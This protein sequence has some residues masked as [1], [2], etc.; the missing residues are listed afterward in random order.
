MPLAAGSRLGSFEVL[1][2]LGAGG[3]GEVYRARDTE[4]GRDVALKILAPPFSADPD[5]LARFEREAR[6]LAA[7]NHRNIAAIHGVVR[8][9]STRALVLELVPGD[10]L[11]DRIARGPLPIDQALAIADQ[12]AEALDAAHERS[13]VHRDLKPANIKITGDG[14]VKVLDFGIAKALAADSDAST[15]ESHHTHAGVVIGTR[16]YMSPEQTRGLPVDKRTDVWAFGCVLYEML[17]GRRAFGGAT[18]TEITTAV[19]ELEPEW[20]ALPA[21]TP[22]P[23]RRLLKRTLAKDP[24]RRLRDIADA[25]IDLEEGLRQFHGERPSSPAT[26]QGFRPANTRWRVHAAWGVAVVVLLAIGFS[27]RIGPWSS[28]GV[29]EVTHLTVPLPGPFTQAWP[30]LAVS[31]DGRMIAVA[32]TAGITIRDLRSEQPR[33]LTGTGESTTP[34]FSPDGAWVGFHADGRLRKVA[35]EGGLPITIAD[36]GGSQRGF[37]WLPD[38]AIIAGHTNGPLSTIAPEGG[39]IAPLTVLDRARDETSHRWPH[40]IHGHG[41]LLYAAGSSVSANEWNSAHIVA[42]ALDTGERRVIVQRGSMPAYGDGHLFYVSGRSLLAQRFDPD[43]MEVSGPVITVLPDVMRVASGAAWFA[44][45]TNGTLA[46]VRRTPPS[47]RRFMW[48]DRQGRM[49]PAPIPPAFYGQHLRLSPDGSRVITTISDPDTDIWIF[50]VARGTGTRIT[51]DGKSLWPIWIR[52]GSEI[53]Y[54]TMRGGPALLRSRRTNGTGEEALL[55]ENALINRAFDWSPGG[56]LVITQVRDA[57][58]LWTLRPGSEP[59]PYYSP[60]GDVTEARLSPDG[61]WLAFRSNE[62]GRN[63]VYLRPFPDVDGERRQVS[64]AGGTLG[65]WGRDSREL[66]FRSGNE[67]WS[68]TVAA[69]GAVG[70]PRRLFASTLP[71]VDAFDMTPDGRLLFLVDDQPSPQPTEFQLTFNVGTE[72]RR[73]AAAQ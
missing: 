67:I 32:S 25:R 56:E 18:A 46:A 20:A 29:A 49:T 9:D 38:G 36:L 73:L 65:I 14:T 7:L 1:S 54:S 10:T 23:I 33:L 53:V 61:R 60:R 50:D 57:L 39:A 42:H 72:V 5:G 40:V 58:H 59:R 68:A 19:L 26:P 62:S 4:L 15:I 11:A 45:S 6:L 43:R 63:E 41:V 64:R 55:L 34:F 70:E 35:V 12:I 52:D 13:I 71:L 21:A 66:L 30:M 16:A 47:P 48:F 37:S 69:D 17:T 3:M 22:E 2:S 51:T 28:P 24:R 44:V 31:A 27:S 8:H